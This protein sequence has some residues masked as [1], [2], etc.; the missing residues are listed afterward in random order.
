MKTFAKLNQK[1]CPDCG[2]D[3]SAS[4]ILYG[5]YRDRYKDESHPE[6]KLYVCGECYIGES[7]NK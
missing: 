4:D 1:K 3:L 7:P 2:R 6:G 5:V